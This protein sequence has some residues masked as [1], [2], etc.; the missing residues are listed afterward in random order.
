M[1]YWMVIHDRPAFLEEPH[2]I[3][4]SDKYGKIN[5]ISKGDKILYYSRGESVIINSYD[6][7]TH[8]QE[9]QFPDDDKRQAWS[10]TLFCYRIRS[11][12]GK[13]EVNVPTQDILA[14]LKLK[15]FPT[16]KAL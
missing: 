3:G 8:G 1:K 2:Y 12:L 14:A 5:K 9:K 6:V 4:K 13:R 7:T 16:M 11:R 15:S 10:G